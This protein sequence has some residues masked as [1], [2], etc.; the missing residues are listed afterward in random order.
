MI[1]ESK[2]KY[3]CLIE[4]VLPDFFNLDIVDNFADANLK[5]SKNYDNIYL[6]LYFLPL[7]PMI[8]APEKHFNLPFS[9]VRGFEQDK[10]HFLG[11]YLLKKI[12]DRGSINENTSVTIAVDSNYTNKEN[13]FK[14]MSASNIIYIP[15]HLNETLEAL[16]I[17]V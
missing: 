6:D 11:E 13:E 14:K 7:Y 12:R 4:D 17:K 10:I 3:R 5:L 15:S 16:G 8:P 2:L 1:V 9:V